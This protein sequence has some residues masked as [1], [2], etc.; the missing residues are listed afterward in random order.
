MG[1]E[2]IKWHVLNS[3]GVGSV[4]WYFPPT[5]AMEEESVSF[6]L[7]IEAGLWLLQLYAC[8]KLVSSIIFKR[9]IFWIL[10]KAFELSNSNNGNEKT[11]TLLKWS[12]KRSEKLSTAF[13]VWSHFLFFI[14]M[15]VISWFPSLLSWCLW[16]PYLHRYWT[17]LQDFCGI[18]L[19]HCLL[20][21]HQKN[22]FA[23]Q[24]ILEAIVRKHEYSEWRKTL[25]NFRVFGLHFNEK[26]KNVE[27][28]R[29]TT[30]S[31][32]LHSTF[33]MQLNST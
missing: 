23:Y 30:S 12:E 17:N 28:T 1:H 31:I 15:R 7:L 33:H 19:W 26:M 18:W 27:N 24:R 22:S 32:P 4:S 6:S 9:W 13:F 14:F 29:S 11:E 10:K 3:R 21:F 25:L 16:R 2:M 8:V 5:N 20:H